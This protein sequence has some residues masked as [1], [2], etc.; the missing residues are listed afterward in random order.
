MS[1]SNKFAANQQCAIIIVIISD[2]S[3]E[4]TGTKFLT[5]TESYFYRSKL[6]GQ[7]YYVK[8]ELKLRADWNGCT[9]EKF[10]IRIDIASFR[11]LTCFHR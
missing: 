4:Y 2:S 10:V 11:I 7:V 3:C 5:R 9:D 8:H 6:S 1:D